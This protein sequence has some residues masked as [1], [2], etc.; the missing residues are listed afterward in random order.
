MK[1]FLL[2]L[3]VLI[4]TAT[5]A[6]LLTFS[7]SFI[8][9][10]DAGVTITV[11]ANK[12]NLGLV[13]NTGTVYIHSGVIT[14]LSTSA[15]DWR[16]VKLGGTPNLF[17]TAQPT[18]ACTSLGG[19][20]Y[21]FSYPSDIRSF[22]GVP[23]GESILKISILFRSTNGQNV[24]RNLDGSDMYVPVYS[25]SIGTR[26]TVPLM[27]P[28]FT[29]VPEP[30]SRA[31][32]D[33]L[34]ITAIANLSS[35]QRIL[36]NGVQVQSSTATTT[37]S[38][39][40]VLT[41]VGSNKVV[42]EATSGTT[43]RDSFTFFVA[44]PTPVAPLP[45]GVREGINY[46]PNNT[47]ATLVLFAPFKNRVTIIG[48]FPGS[49][50]VETVAY[51]MTKT[52]DGNYWWKTISGLTPGQEY[53]YQYL[54]DGIIRIGDP[55]TE[56]VLDPF[57]DPFI[58][59]TTFPNLKPYP[60]GQQGIVSVLQTN[61][62][63]YTWQVPNF[64][65]PN[66]KAIVVYELL[67]R[68]FIANHD[69][70]TMKDTIPYLKKLGIN[71]IHIMPFNEFEG[72]QSWGYNPNY[73]FAPDKFYGPKND[74]KSFI[75][76]CHQNGIA[77]VMDMVMNHVFGSGPQALLYFNN[78]LGE[79]AANNPWLNRQAPHPFSVGYDFNHTT[80]ATK[81]LVDRVVQHWLTE[82]KLDGFRWD[83][84]KGFTQRQ[85]GT[86]AGCWS[87]Y[88]FD[89]VQTWKRIYD[90][91]QAASPN[92]YCILEHLGI[93]QEENELS[94]YGMLLWGKQTDEY[95]QV[96]MG[97]IQNSDYSRI[98]HTARGFNQPHLLGYAESHDEERT[99]YKN[100]TFGNQSGANGYN[101][102]L[103]AT[104]LRRQEMLVAQLLTV[105]GPKMFW[106]FAEL[107]YDITI[108]ACANTT[109]NPDCRT[110][111]KP[112][113]WNY[114]DVP[115]RRRLN[116][117]YASLNY[118]RLQK[119]DAFALGNMQWG[120]GGLFKWLKLQ[121]STLNLVVVANMDVNNHTGTVAF[122]TA[123]TYYDYLLGGTFT[124]TG[125]TQ[126]F[127]L[128]PGEYHVY[129]DQNIT[130]PVLPPPV[131][132]NPT[133]PI[134][135]IRVLVYPNPVKTDALIEYDMPE[136][137]KVFITVHNAQGQQ[138]GTIYQGFKNIGTHQISLNSNGFNAQKLQSGMYFLHLNLNGNK[139]VEKLLIQH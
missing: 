44:G 55:Y 110:D 33:A 16:Y 2:S 111:N 38:A 53:A 12:G 60:T 100:I 24:Q 127:N 71:T 103:L 22:Y 114:L 58:L 52:P 70:K 29:P 54:V 76:A 99:M 72:N 131:V 133:G 138:L 119:Q 43:A 83:L 130:G 28:T 21:R 122:P 1:Q 129:I 123:G 89:R 25:T 42:V 104:A 96:S 56:K 77:V 107:G 118:L 37:L 18:L 45:A 32:G 81:Y 66:K 106:Q 5:Q 14:S 17:T 11:D 137:G 80:A 30:F 63:G 31:V 128:S 90:V 94:N 19:G 132:V 8:K 20:L 86:D 74:V 82:Y 101:V 105:V 13:T 116:L 57:N 79:P 4:A 9:D 26:I 61:A 6:Q 95:N 112:I 23:A 93:D 34:P 102:R 135:N 87:N 65:R 48:E 113:T 59:P 35:N 40:P 68:D 139:R 15:S 136:N 91:M 51:Q 3:L 126:T 115:E 121:H 92:S 97:Y 134:Q 75:D 109:I 49:G 88:D 125:S 98:I 64:V 36:L 27:Q 78:A 108:N 69:F 50:F 85:C 67:L 117:I 47:E 41:Q 84:S 46:N 39:N 7:P 73:F 10:N 120:T 124:S 62:P